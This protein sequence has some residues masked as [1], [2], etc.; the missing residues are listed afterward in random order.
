MNLFLKTLIIIN[1]KKS[2]FLLIEN[3]QMTDRA[4]H[5]LGPKRQP[6]HRGLSNTQY[7]FNKSDSKFIPQLK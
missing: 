7:S 1:I 2:N 3:S 5:P 6:T 4:I